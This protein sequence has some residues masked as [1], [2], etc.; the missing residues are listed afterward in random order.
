MK[1]SLSD[2]LTVGKGCNLPH[3]PLLSH[4]VSWCCTYLLIPKLC[5]AFNTPGR[6]QQQSSFDWRMEQ[7]QSCPSRHRAET[8]C[9]LAET[10]RWYQCSLWRPQH[11]IF[12]NSTHALSANKTEEGTPDLQPIT[13]PVPWCV[14]KR[15]PQKCICITCGSISI[16]VQP[17][18]QTNSWCRSEDLLTITRNQQSWSLTRVQNVFW[19][20]RLTHTYS[21]F[22]ITQHEWTGEFTIPALAVLCV[23]GRIILKADLSLLHKCATWKR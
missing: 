1:Q 10:T 16:T 19:V 8:P 11:L 23:D 5:L 18:T 17:S 21:F 13:T 2:V 20:L 12:T 3:E 4:R 15:S 14:L 6:E 7:T 22:E 9:S